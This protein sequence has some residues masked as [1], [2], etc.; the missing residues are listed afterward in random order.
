MSENSFNK[1]ESVFWVSEWIEIEVSFLFF[2]MCFWKFL[3]IR[4]NKIGNFSLW[5][6][7]ILKTFFC[8]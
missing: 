7:R 5:I 4:I 1:G 8:V 3:Q 6:L 2:E